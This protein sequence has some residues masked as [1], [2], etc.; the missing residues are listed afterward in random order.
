M[1]FGLVRSKNTIAI[2][3]YFTMRNCIIFNTFEIF[4]CNNPRSRCSVFTNQKFT[5]HHQV[6][7]FAKLSLAGK[8]IIINSFYTGC[9]S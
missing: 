9:S 7:V 3:M 4:R 8:F 5:D 2:T 1:R 6:A